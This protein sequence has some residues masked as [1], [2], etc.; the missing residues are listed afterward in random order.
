MLTVMKSF[1]KNTEKMVVILGSMNEGVKSG[2]EMLATKQ[3]ETIATIKRGVEEMREFRTET[4]QKF[5]N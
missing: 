5:A 3:D 1:E 4:Q 2:N